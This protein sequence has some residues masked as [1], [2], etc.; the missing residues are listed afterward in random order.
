MSKILDGKVVRDQIMVELKEKISDFK[1]VPNLAIIKIGENPDSDIYIRN[2]INF[3]KNIG[4]N[5]YVVNFPVGEI[6][7]EMLLAGIEKLNND[8]DV[9]GIIIQSPL[10]SPL[11]WVEAVERVAPE[12]DV[13]GL[14]SVNVKKLIAND[15]MGIVPATARGVLTLLN[16]YKIPVKDKKVVVMGRSALVGQPITNLMINNGATVT[17]VHSQ[18]LE[19][20][21]IT[22]EAD[23]LIVA[24]GKPE[25]VGAEFVKEGAVVID[26][27]ISTIINGDGTKKIYGDV[28]FDS[29]S[30]LVSVISPVPGG[31]GPMTVAS[32]FQNLFYTF[33][34]Q[35]MLY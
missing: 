21:K 27:G 34:R 9:H 2:K 25:Y 35:T 4:V 10:P 3:A 15:K 31:I 16:Y 22:R 29:V 23:I 13:D 1:I 12:K 8:P 24:I 14:C 17:V 30:P 20:E 26:V 11:N 7:Q 5:A 33:Q 28:D 18:T 32:L 6:S 19:P